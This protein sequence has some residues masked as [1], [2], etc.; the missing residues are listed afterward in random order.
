MMEARIAGKQP[1]SV[2]AESDTVDRALD[3][4]VKKLEK[5]LASEF[6]RQDNPRAR[7][8]FTPPADDTDSDE[9]PS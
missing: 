3:G 2:T 8:R 9:E 5:K 7:T 4:A 1:F 6:D